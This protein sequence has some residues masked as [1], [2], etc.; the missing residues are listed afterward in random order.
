M[1]CR[2]GSFRRLDLFAARHRARWA[3]VR[4]DVRIGDRAVLCDEGGNVKLSDTQLQ[5]LADHLAE[6]TLRAA[7]DLPLLLLRLDEWSPA[8][9]TSPSTDGGRAGGTSKPVER[10]TI[11]NS[12]DR[13]EDPDHEHS[14]E[15]RV[16][17]QW[18]I[19]DHVKK[20]RELVGFFDTLERALN[21]YDRIVRFLTPLEQE[22][23]RRLAEEEAATGSTCANGNCGAWITGTRDDRAR[24]GRCNVCYEFHRTHGGDDRPHAL[25]HREPIP[26][27]NQCIRRVSVV[28]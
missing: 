2:V 18:R 17:D 21:D 9:T 1:A 3:A 12:C 19:D 23:A 14:K 24:A 13:G 27:C 4:C 15:C 5:H 28:Q 7:T 25:V 20:R 26:E 22:K 16:K 10:K 11:P 6:R 8:A